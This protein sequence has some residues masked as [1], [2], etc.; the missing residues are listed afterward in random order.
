MI[1]GGGPRVSLIAPVK[2]E[3]E[4][5]PAA[6]HRI[7][8]WSAQTRFPLEVVVVDDGSDDGAATV[9]E[10]FKRRLP[11]LRVIRHALPRGGDGAL[12]TGFAAARAPI[13]AFSDAI[14]SA[15]I[16]RLPRLLAAIVEGA[17]VAVGTSRVEQR[18]HD[19]APGSLRGLADRV[20]DGLAAMLPTA[21][22]H[23]PEGDFTAFRVSA[24]KALLRRSEQEGL[25]FDADWPALAREL[26]LRVVAVPLARRQANRSPVPLERPARHGS[27]ELRPEPSGLAA[28]PPSAVP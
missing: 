5:L 15:P 9:A 25:D 13:V 1:A 21:H 3:A 14:L 22:G 7:A 12:R 2:N 23:D 27:D 28:S 8:A 6:L 10:S 16:D 20:L 19:A 4:R 18:P 24:V 26:R 17:D 11:S